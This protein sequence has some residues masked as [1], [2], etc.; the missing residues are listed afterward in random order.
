MISERARGVLR[1][2]RDYPSVPAN[3]K[4]SKS[5]YV[6]TKAAAHELAERLNNAR[7]AATVEDIIGAGGSA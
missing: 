3:G 2:V 4:T 5:G 1:I 6:Q 7:N